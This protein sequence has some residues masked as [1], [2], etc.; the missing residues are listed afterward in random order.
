MR[1]YAINVLVDRSDCE[2]A[3][4][5]FEDKPSFAEL[6]GK[7][8]HEAEFGTLMTNFN[9]IRAGALHRANGGYLVMDVI[10]VLSY[11]LAWEGL[12]RAIKSGEL[13]VRSL[14]DDIGLV[15]T[16][17]LEPQPIPLDL[18]VILI[19]ERIHYYL[20][21]RYD[22]E[23]SELFKIAADFE[24]QIERNDENIEHRARLLATVVRQENL[25]HITG[26]ATM[27]R[28]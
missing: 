13:S 2:G 11:P 5:V 24:D 27:T 12:K 25:K 18:K 9:L 26:Q 10:K 4:V 8:E 3:P 19:G 23:F 17:T 22:P 7:I 16:V 14:G 20:L 6:I 28:K 15:S 21:D 1:R